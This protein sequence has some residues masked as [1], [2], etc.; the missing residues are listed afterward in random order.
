MSAE[1]DL[2]DYDLHVIFSPSGAGS[3][4]QALKE[5]GRSGRIICPFDNFSFGPI[6]SDD[7]ETRAEWV[8]D[9]LGYSDWHDVTVFNEPVLT[10]SLSSTRAPIVWVS[11]N[12]TASYAGFLWWLS[13]MGEAPCSI[14]ER[15]GLSLLPASDLIGFFDHQV[16]LPAQ[17]REQYRAAWKQL[18]SEN[19]AL[20][21][22]EDGK[23]VSK[24]ID[25]FDAALLRLA[26]PEWQKMSR[27]VAELL[28]EFFDADLYQTGDFVLGAGLAALADDGALE[29]RGEALNMLQCEMRLPGKSG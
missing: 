15:D 4:K 22:I 10:T 13:H 9:V 21:V 16:P 5:S 19:A 17:E 12:Q 24:E 3:L 7:A 2:P 29:W 14:I 20:R 23:L 11:L 27:I 28:A 25:F 1:P 8:D 6:A 26:T 18:C